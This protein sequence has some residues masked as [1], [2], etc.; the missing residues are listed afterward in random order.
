MNVKIKPQLLS[1]NVKVPSSKSFAHRAIIAASLASGKSIISNVTLSNDILATL[2]AVEQLGAKYSIKDDVVTVV[3]IDKICD[4]EITIDCNESG[5]TLRFMLPIAGMLSSNYVNFIG[6][7]K[8]GLRPMKIYENLY[9]DENLF[10]EDSSLLNENNYLDLKIKGSILNDEI[11][12]DGNVSSQFLTGL[13]YSL[14]LKDRDSV[15]YV[16]D[17]QSKGY[18]DITLDVLKVFNIEIENVNYEKFIIK[19]NQKYKATNYVVEGDYS[20]E[21]FFEIA[22]LIGSNINILG[23]NENSIQGDKKIVEFSNLLK[24]KNNHY[25]FDC[26]D[27][28]DIV[29]VLSVGCA[30]YDGSVDI[31][32]I[33]RLKIKEC[34]R[35]EAVYT[36]L[37]KLGANVTKTD[38]SLSFIG[39][40]K[41][42]GADCDAWND[43]RMAMMLAIAATKADSFV[44]I[45]DAQSVSKSYPLF[46]EDYKSLGGIVE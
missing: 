23:M 9:K 6:K 36:E 3:G 16:N 1:G 45:K 42:N 39:V 43:H 4:K 31:I 41:F 2:S 11:H 10:Y 35:L 40:N 19:G 32:N 20:Q 22:N 26:K 25:V 5:S 15:I 27:C 34:D 12:I 46:F 8:L 29:P 14:S 33:E 37:K 13:I 7:G 17:L 44:T 18:I 21:A 24:T 30:L 28:P 38:S